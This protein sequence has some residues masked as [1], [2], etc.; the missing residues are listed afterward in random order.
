MSPERLASMIDHTF[1]KSHGPPADVERLCAEALEHRFAAVCVHPSE[2]RRCAELLG[3]SGVAVATVS[4]FPLGQNTT[5]MK[6]AEAEDAVELGAREVDM[7]I[8]VRALQAGELG[9]VR[10][11]I[12]AV[13]AA[14]REAGALCKVIIEACY[15]T[16]GQKI[17]AC[18]A[19]KEAGAHFVKTS[20]GFASGVPVNGATV[21]DVRLMRRTVGPDMGV[22][23]AGGIRDL[24]TALAMIGAGATRLGTSAGAQIMRELALSSPRAQ[25]GQ[26]CL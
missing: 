3:S 23:A 8:N 17:A 22:K 2:I 11:E 21:E 19:A 18:L 20:T 24:A 7:V 13:A 26:P 1:L 16:E 14:C 6:I 5:R 9:Y 10:E 12:R 25:D 15:L 4:G